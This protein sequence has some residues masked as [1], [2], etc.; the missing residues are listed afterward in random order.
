[1][2]TH[3]QDILNP[4]RA[5]ARAAANQAATQKADQLARTE[6]ESEAQSSETAVYG[7]K[8][9]VVAGENGSTEGLTK[10]LLEEAIGHYGVESVLGDK[11]NAL[12]ALVSLE[13]RG[14]PEYEALRKLYGERPR[15]VAAEY[16]AK[17]AR[18][19]IRNPSMWTKVK[20]WFNSLARVLDFRAP[21]TDAELRV[22][23]ARAKGAMEKGDR[24]SSVP[25]ETPRLSLRAK[26][27]EE[28]P[29]RRSL[30]GP[31]WF[32]SAYDELS[33]NLDTNYTEGVARCR[34]ISHDC[35]LRS[36][37]IVDQASPGIGKI[38]TRLYAGSAITL[39]CKS[40]SPLEKECPTFPPCAPTLSTIRPAAQ[41]S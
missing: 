20:A 9:Y 6:S 22:T 28:E 19:E 18:D 31:Q 38:V 16:I 3:V 7:D 11:F 39:W 23:L 12:T 4:A 1:L 36:T 29:V 5:K 10:A 17:L 41:L 40:T 35:L 26:A 37:A 13:M 33:R 30:K 27:E 14:R 25:F 15:T 21:F 2:P 34:V 32:R 8:I 24:R